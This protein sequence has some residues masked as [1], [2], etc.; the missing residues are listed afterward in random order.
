MLVTLSWIEKNYTKFNKLYFNGILPSVKFKI[1]NSRQTWGYASYKIN[2]KNNTIEPI[3]LTMSNYYDS[4]E[5]VKISTLLHEMIHIYDYTINPQHFVT[6][7]KRV[8]GYNAHGLFF[9]KECNRLKKFGF[10]ISSIVTYKELTSSSKSKHAEELENKKVKSTIICVVYGFNGNN[11]FIKTND[12]NIDTFM[13]CLLCVNFN[14][15]LG[16]VKNIVLYRIK[17]KNIASMRSC[18][19]TIKGFKYSDSVT[20]AKLITIGASKMKM[21]VKYKKIANLMITK[22]A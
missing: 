10:D 14:R 8:R 20:K 4:P 22:C 7:G 3:S 11:Y 17:D 16:G 12:A 6:N 19:T 5:E 2:C 21:P 18:K 15:C 9:E 1:S 13:H